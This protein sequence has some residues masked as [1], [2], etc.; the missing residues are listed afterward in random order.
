MKATEDKKLEEMVKT[1]SN[2]CRAQGYPLVLSIG[3]GE[4]VNGDSV[5]ACYGN[6]FLIFKQVATFVAQVDETK[7][8]GFFKTAAYCF[9]KTVEHF[10]N[11][12]EGKI[13]GG[14]AEAK[15]YVN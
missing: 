3:N 2:Y 11:Y 15:K 6:E 13:F 8:N 9:Q 7:I 12:D 10:E 1:L 4:E 14:K 5:I